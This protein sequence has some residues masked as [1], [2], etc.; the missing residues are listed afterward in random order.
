[1]ESIW[2]KDIARPAFK[3]LNRNIKTD[4]LIIGGGMAGILCAYKLNQAGVDCVIAEAGVICGGVSQ[5]TTA[6]ITCQ[7][8]AIYDKMIRRFGIETARSYVCAQKKAFNDY[9]EL[10]KEIDCDFKNADSYVFSLNDMYKMQNE[11]DALN[12]IGC[13]ADFRTKIPLNFK[14]AGA[15]RIKNQAEF[16]PLKFAYA[17][18]KDLNV[19]EHTRVLN[20]L[21]DGAVTNN[22]RINAKRI[23]VATHFPI[24]D[25]HGFYFLKMYQHRSYV[26]ALKNTSDV[27]G[28]YVEDNECGLS[29]RNY[30]DL[31]LLGGGGHRVGKKGGGWQALR[32]FAAKHYPKAQEI[33]HFA[34]QDCK[35]LDDI[36]YIGKYSKNTPNLYV[37]TGFNKW[38]M[39][40]S[41]CAADVL[42]D[43]ILEKHNEY[44]YVFS[45]SRTI[46]R[47]QLFINAG[48]SVLG[49]L[50]PTTPRC[51]HLGCALKYNRQ[52]HTWDC[53]CHG[54]RFTKDGKV[55]N[56]PAKKDL[57]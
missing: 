51:T 38:G 40:N 32:S 50:T 42:V 52:E 12:D 19:F 49:F 53:S 27:N 36:P 46:M 9:S 5:N 10:C 13:D 15:V 47:K 41:M 1:M 57:K 16:N 11:A 37:A 20:L 35:T 39:T 18:A 17:I 6:K 33:A 14:I 31:L 23:I 8:G 21:P 4:V 29:F 2:N 28:M 34:T 3:P 48:E 54:S 45:P 25:K 43:L 44:A 22:G 55:I 30:K 24:T 7:H 26:L 56:N